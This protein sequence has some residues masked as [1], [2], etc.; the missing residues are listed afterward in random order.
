MRNDKNNNNNSN[1]IINNTNEI[2][3]TAA[4]ILVAFVVASV[5]QCLLF[6]QVGFSSTFRARFAAITR[7]GNIMEY[8]HVTGT[9]YSDK[10]IKY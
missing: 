7:L 8:T 9:F 4:V 2:V 10:Y 6:L 1:G 3:T 5:V